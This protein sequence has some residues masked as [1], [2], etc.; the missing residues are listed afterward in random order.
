MT[1]IILMRRKTNKYQH[2]ITKF[3]KEPKYIWGNK[4]LIKREMAVAKKLFLKIKDEKF[5]TQA[6]LPFELNSLA[7]F[8]SEDGVAFLNLEA[9]RLK[10]RLNKPIQYEIQEDKTGEDKDIKTK[11]NKTLM[12]FL[13]DAS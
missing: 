5:W 2:L 12:D 3:L 13:K 4:G 11:N 8:L 7:W 9:K 1:S 10:L 6:Y